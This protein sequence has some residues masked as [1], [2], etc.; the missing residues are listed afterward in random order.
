MANAKNWLVYKIHDD[1]L[2][3]A[4]RKYIRGRLVD[5]GCGTKPYEKLLAPFVEEHIGVDHEATLH[6]KSNVNLWGTAYNIPVEDE[7]FDSAICTAVLEHLEE[8][9]NAL[10]ECF[11]ILK[12]NGHAIYSIPFIWH[13]HEE[14][15]DFYR[16]SKYGIRYLFEKTGFQI[17]ELIAL[18]GFWV[19]FGQLFVY[20]IYRFKRGPLMWI[21]IIDAIGLV[22]QGIS[23][24]LDKID[25]SEKWTWMYMVVAKKL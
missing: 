17:V 16:Y 2:L 8:P 3:I 22:I 25:K 24:L 4:A 21:P 18:S 10:R 14:P 23:Y 6:D 13:L 7:F 15:R 1:S 12:P 11:R 5:I 19:T 9:E 20:N